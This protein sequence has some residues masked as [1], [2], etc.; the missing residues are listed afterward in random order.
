MDKGPVFAGPSLGP[1]IIAIQSGAIGAGSGQDG[2]RSLHLRYQSCHINYGRELTAVG[3]IA[4]V[5]RR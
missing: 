5:Q 2:R 1:H 3:S 4:L